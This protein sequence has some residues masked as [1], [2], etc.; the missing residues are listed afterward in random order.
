MSRAKRRYRICEER[1]RRG[2][3]IAGYLQKT[4]WYKDVS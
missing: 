1:E 4:I 3:G 2:T